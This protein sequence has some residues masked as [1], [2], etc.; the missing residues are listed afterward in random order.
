MVLVR[1]TTSRQ[2]CRD[3]SKNTIWIYFTYCS[4]SKDG[5]G[6]LRGKSLP[7]LPRAQE[8]LILSVLV[9]RNPAHALKQREPQRYPERVCLDFSVISITCSLGNPNT[10]QKP[11][12]THIS[13][14][15]GKRPSKTICYI[16][17]PTMSESLD[18][19]LK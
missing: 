12:D 14:C 7:A 15:F 13:S 6:G 17:P 19:F 10:P 3:F 1:R 16:L 8:H 18:L 5:G 2:L 9:M 11:N 4:H